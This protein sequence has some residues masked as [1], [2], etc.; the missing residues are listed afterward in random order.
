MPCRPHKKDKRLGVQRPYLQTSLASAVLPGVCEK[1][2]SAID[3]KGSV[4]ISYAGGTGGSSPRKIDPQ[5]I[6]NGKEG[7]KVKAYC[8]FAKDTRHFYL[9]K[10]QRIDDYDWKANIQPTGMFLVLLLFC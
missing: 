8:H 7:Q 4:Y 3:A 6:E 1:V 2:Q 5:V 10:I 9:H